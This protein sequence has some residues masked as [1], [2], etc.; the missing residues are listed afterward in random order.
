MRRLWLIGAL[1]LL[2]GP[3]V[4]WSRFLQDHDIRRR[5]SPIDA[6]QPTYAAYWQFLDDARRDV[7][8]GSSY[9]IQAGNADAETM[10]FMISAGLFG[11][12][13]PYPATYVWTAQAGGGRQAKYV[14]IFGQAD[15]PTDATLVRRVRGGRVCIRGAR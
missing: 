13:S 7:P 9:T 15:C 3:A 10:I 5:S 11:G 4:T 14:L 12:V 1:A 6:A 8:D 2:A